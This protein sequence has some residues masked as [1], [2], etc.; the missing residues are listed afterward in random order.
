MGKP[1]QNVPNECINSLMYDIIIHS[2]VSLRQLN[3]S[4]SSLN[5]GQYVLLQG[6]CIHVRNDTCMCIFF[7]KFS[8]GK[9]ERAPH[10]ANFF[11]VFPIHHAESMLLLFFFC[12]YQNDR[13]H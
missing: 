4:Q 9:R 3:F 6:F 13:V 1:L 10:K 12:T 2:G 11:S 5:Y 7:V 8:C